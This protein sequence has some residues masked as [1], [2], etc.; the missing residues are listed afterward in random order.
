[1]DELIIVKY[2]DEGSSYLLAIVD[3]VGHEYLGRYWLGSLEKS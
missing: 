3:Q 1:M 2:E